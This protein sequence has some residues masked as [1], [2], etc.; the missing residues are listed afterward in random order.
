MK[1]E[2][3]FDESAFEHD[4]TIDNNEWEEYNAEEIYEFGGVDYGE[5]QPSKP[6]WRDIIE[7]IPY[8]LLYLIV[9]GLIT[10]CIVYAK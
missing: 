7:A 3:I 5:T 4:E 6:L 8:I 2:D 10:Y 1:I 9:C